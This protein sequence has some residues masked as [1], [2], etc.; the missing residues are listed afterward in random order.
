MIVRSVILL[1]FLLLVGCSG[2]INTGGTNLA[3]LYSPH[4]VVNRPIFSYQHED[5]QI[6]SL[7][8]SIP[9]E[10]LLY[11]RD[12]REEFYL[13]SFE[14][15]VTVLSYPGQRRPIYTSTLPFTDTLRIMPGRI[16]ERDLTFPLAMGD[17]YWLYLGFND[18]NRRNSY[19]KLVHIDKRSPFSQ[20]FFNIIDNIGDTL[21]FH[22]FGFLNLTGNIGLKPSEG[23]IGTLEVSHFTPPS[24]FPDVPFLVREAGNEQGEENQPTATKT[25]TSNG[26]GFL[27]DLSENGF[28][29][30]NEPGVMQNGF[31]AINFWENFPLMPNDERYLHPLRYITTTPEFDRMLQLNDHELAAERFWI[32]N[33]GNPDRAE[34]VMNRYT[35][36]VIRANE[37]FTSVQPGWQTDRGMI[38][39]V[40]GPPDQVFH[41][42]D[43]ETWIYEQTMQTP[44]TE[45]IFKRNNN[46]LTNNDLLLVR[47]ITYERFWNIAVANWRR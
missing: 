21:F 36:R 12:A 35:Q 43:G 34:T 30:I 47:N 9:E 32:R 11:V 24:N 14:V 45:L 6:S 38:Y 15:S 16:V 7:R 20:G 28:F 31:S 37:L 40:F 26:H 25:I 5:A 46:I 8:V 13:S 39:I 17:A 19:N 42:R 41:N 44:H 27:V 33:T 3:V 1:C 29:R 22:P 2:L 4:S 18:K 10:G 23:D